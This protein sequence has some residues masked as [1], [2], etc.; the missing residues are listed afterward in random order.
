MMNVQG[1][2]LRR[3]ALPLDKFI[4]FCLKYVKINLVT[5]RRRQDLELAVV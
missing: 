2:A 5:L 3:N 1:I 4:Y